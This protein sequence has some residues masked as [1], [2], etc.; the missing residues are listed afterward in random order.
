M[1]EAVAGM[2]KREI[3]HL[4]EVPITKI[5]K[6]EGEF[7][8]WLVENIDILEHY[9]KLPKIDKESIE[10][11]KETGTGRFFV[12]IFAKTVEEPKKTVIIEN[13]FGSSD[14]DHLGK[15]LTYARGTD[16]DI[17]VWIVEKA[18]DEHRSVIKWLNDLTDKFFFL[19]EVKGFRIR[20]SPVAIAF[21]PTE[22]PNNWEKIL[23]TRF[24][25]SPQEYE[26]YRFFLNVYNGLISDLDPD[27][28]REPSINTGRNEYYIFNYLKGTDSLVHFE[29]TLFKRPKP[30]FAVGLHCETSDKEFNKQ[31]VDCI[32]MKVG[33]KLKS[34]FREHVEAGFWRPN[35]K[36]TRIHI[37]IPEI[38]L[39]EDNARRI[40]NIASE[41]FKIVYPAAETCLKKLKK[42]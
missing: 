7:S 23:R 29:I 42:E 16:A 12:D 32:N 37:K 18:L 20:D 21:F 13:Q 26:L 5:F 25:L 30:H 22:T 2:M 6:N 34:K 31:L 28:V 39:T 8:D 27:I 41:F 11:E 35:G 36:W 4:S 9:I 17:V 40:A 15:I 33:E 24:K 10:R 38:E 14:H 1:D 3:S 19:V